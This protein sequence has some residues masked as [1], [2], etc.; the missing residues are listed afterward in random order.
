MVLFSIALLADA[1]L[2]SSKR[3]VRVHRPYLVKCNVQ[4]RRDLE[5]AIIAKYRHKRTKTDWL[6]PDVRQCIILCGI[7]YRMAYSASKG[8]T[9]RM[10]YKSD[11]TDFV[12]LDQRGVFVAI[13]EFQWSIVRVA[14]CLR[15][16]QHSANTRQLQRRGQ[17]DQLMIPDRETILKMRLQQQ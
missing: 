6:I 12:F 5:I 7:Q 13:V 8:K 4:V 15:H 1:Y 11:Q 2:V 14:R 16:A 10:R 3:S 9:S 17:F